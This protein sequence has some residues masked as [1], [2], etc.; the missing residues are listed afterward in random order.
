MARSQVTGASLL[1]SFPQTLQGESILGET[2]TA[3]GP[4]VP[5]RQYFGLTAIYPLEL[6]TSVVRSKAANGCGPEQGSLK[7]ESKGCS[8]ASLAAKDD[9]GTQ[10]NFLQACD[11]SLQ[12]FRHRA[13]FWPAKVV[14]RNSPVGKPTKTLSFQLSPAGGS[15]YTGDVGARRRAICECSVFGT[16]WLQKQARLSFFGS[17]R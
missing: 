4:T 17:F 11:F 13:R 9:D 12:T 3:N 7:M 15:Q 1:P 5:P 16:S 6:V 8:A 14:L 10:G 2:A